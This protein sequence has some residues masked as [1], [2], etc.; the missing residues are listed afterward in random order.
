MN[1]PLGLVWRGGTLYVSSFGRVDAFGDFDGEI[2]GTAIEAFP[3]C[4][5]RPRRSRAFF[6]HVR[7]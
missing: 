7:L 6:P 2:N 4:R 3:Q 1:F 5:G